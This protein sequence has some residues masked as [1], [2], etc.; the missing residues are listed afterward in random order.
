MDTE[1]M[2]EFLGFVLQVIKMADKNARDKIC[3]FFNLVLF[4]TRVSSENCFQS[5]TTLASSI[6]RLNPNL[7]IL[8][9]HQDSSAAG[10]QI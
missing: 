1:E 9:L 5:K 2:F 4:N 7:P 8:I 6:L 10:A 3:I